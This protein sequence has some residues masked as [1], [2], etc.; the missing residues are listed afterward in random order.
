MITSYQE[1]TSLHIRRRPEP[2]I[3]MKEPPVKSRC[4][5]QVLVKVAFGHVISWHVGLAWLRPQDLGIG[6]PVSRALSLWSEGGP[7]DTGPIN[8][9]V[10]DYGGR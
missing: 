6:E 7:S 4:L 1:K 9:L 5:L 3:E 10:S 2:K 8:Q